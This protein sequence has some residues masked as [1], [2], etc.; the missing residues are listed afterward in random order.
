MIES[1]RALIQNQYEAAFRTIKY[2]IERCPDR[3]WHAPICNHA[4][5]Q[6]VFH[7]LYFADLYLGEDPDAV[8]DQP[9]H[10][11]HSAVFTGYEEMEAQVP[12]QTYE[13][14]F[15][16]EYLEHCRKK[17]R[18]AVAKF[19]ESGLAKRSGFSWIDGT[20]AEVHVYNLRHIQHHAAQLSLRLRLDHKIDIP[21]V[22]SGWEQ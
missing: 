20:V 7:A 11:E 5:S 4:Y 14:L 6:T 18:L 9:F 17:A 12:E 22:K 2:C 21:W 19:S 16:E 15:I 1:Y 10:V 13:R 8:K 3:S